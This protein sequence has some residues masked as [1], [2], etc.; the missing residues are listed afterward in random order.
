MIESILIVI[1]MFCFGVL[2]GPFVKVAYKL[3]LKKLEDKLKGE[4]E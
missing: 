1:V 3:L 4:Q 2:F